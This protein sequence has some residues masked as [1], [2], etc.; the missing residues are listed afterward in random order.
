VG[1]GGGRMKTGMHIQAEGDTVTRVGFT[2]QQ[3]FGLTDASWGTESN[4][5]TKPFTE[6]LA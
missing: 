6:V 5:A 3:A 4:T 1:S 2:I